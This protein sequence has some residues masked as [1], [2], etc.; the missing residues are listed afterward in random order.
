M[1]GETEATDHEETTAHR[2]RGEGDM[3]VRG[4]DFDPRLYGVDIEAGTIDG[5][6]VGLLSAAEIAIVRRRTWDYYNK[7]LARVWVDKEQSKSAT[8]DSRGRD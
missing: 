4:L 8:Q 1:K 3:A 6:Y 5:E 7:Q 2:L